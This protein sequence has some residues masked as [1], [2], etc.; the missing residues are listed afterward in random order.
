MDIVWER[1]GGYKRG[2][3]NTKSG[4]KAFIVPVLRYTRGV[5]QLYS[6]YIEGDKRIACTRATIEKVEQILESR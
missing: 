3:T 2:A 5:R 4:K 6:V 1:V